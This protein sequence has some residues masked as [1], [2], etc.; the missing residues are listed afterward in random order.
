V[1]G[2]DG[3]RRGEFPYLPSQRLSPPYVRLSERVVRAPIPKFCLSGGTLPAM[4][5]LPSGGTLSG[6]ALKEAS[7]HLADALAFRGG[8]RHHLG[9]ELLWHSRRDPRGVAARVSEAQRR[10]ARPRLPGRQVIT[11]LGLARHSIQVRIGDDATVF[12]SHSHLITNSYMAL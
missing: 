1:D 2:L 7:H 5:R 3:G 8:S 10:P 11:G 6:V 4:G 9:A 12:G